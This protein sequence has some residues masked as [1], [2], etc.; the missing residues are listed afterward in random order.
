M[1]VV[2]RAEDLRLRREALKPLCEDLTGDRLAVE[3]LEREARAAAAVNHPNICTVYEVGE[4]QVGKDRGHPF[5]AMELLEG[6][7][8]KERL[9]GRPV[10]IDELFDWAAQI[11]AGLAAAHARGI[12]HRDIKPANLFVT[13]SGQIKILDFGL[14]RRE[15]GR[16]EALAETL[17]KP[18]EA[19]GTVACMS[20]EEACG[21]SLDSRTDLFSFGAVLYEMATGKRAFDGSSMASV[22]DAILNRRVT[23]PSSLNPALPPKLQEIS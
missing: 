22:F 21:E 7:T 16:S 18:N 23:P 10:P 4:G 13:T 2:Y 8:L 19:L 20:P 17:T 5:L 12:I 11:A 3:R 9:G 15:R 1:G 6:Q 14:A